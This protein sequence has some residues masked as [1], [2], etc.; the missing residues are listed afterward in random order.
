MAEKLPFFFKAWVIWIIIMPFR[1]STNEGEEQ[2]VFFGEG[3][4][5]KVVENCRGWAEDIAT[6]CG[7]VRRK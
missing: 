7:V 5:I 3:W 6:G 4:V 1:Y 2:G